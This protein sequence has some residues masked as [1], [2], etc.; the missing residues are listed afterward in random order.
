MN[1]GKTFYARNR[2]EWRA[3]LARHKTAP[4]IWLIYYKKH[5]GKPRVSYNDAVDEALCYG[6]ID[7][8]LKPIDA[9]CYAQ[10][11]SPQPVGRE[12]DP[13]VGAAVGAV[14]GVR[15]AAVCVGDRVD[16]GEPEAGAAAAAC[17]VGAGEAFEGVGQELGWEAWAFV[18]DM[19][20]DAPV[21]GHG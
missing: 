21:F 14:A 20:L 16:D 3:W 6:W 2:R 8:I 11:F 13:D 5:S 15:F 4:E 17:F 19:Q 12:R 18:D 9:D 1:V 7:S 10:R